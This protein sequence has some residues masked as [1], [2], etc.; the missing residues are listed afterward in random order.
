MLIL[1]SIKCY[2]QMSFVS[3]LYTSVKAEFIGSEHFNILYCV[4]SSLMPQ[5]SRLYNGLLSPCPYPPDSIIHIHS[6]LVLCCDEKPYVY[7]IP[8]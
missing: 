8:K 2:V 4:Y 7:P 3:V 6:H 1:F 5:T